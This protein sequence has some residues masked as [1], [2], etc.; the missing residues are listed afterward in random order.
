MDKVKKHIWIIH[1]IIVVAYNIAYLTNTPDIPGFDG[2]NYA[3]PIFYVV[4]ALLAL[5]EYLT[6]KEQVKLTWVVFYLWISASFPL[7]T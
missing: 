7:T 1:I 2:L 5:K 6:T 4:A 3:L